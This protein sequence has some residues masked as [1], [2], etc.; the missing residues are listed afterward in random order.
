MIHKYMYTYIKRLIIILKIRTLSKS[1]G[2]ENSLCRR[3]FHSF[4]S[5]FVSNCFISR[6]PLLCQSLSPVWLCNSMNCSPA[7][8]SVH[9]IS[10]ARM[11]E[12]VPISFSGGSS[13]PRDWTCI[14]CEAGRFFTTEPPGY[15]LYRVNLSEQRLHI[16]RQSCRT[17]NRK[18]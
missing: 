18:Y 9:G 11:L 10:Q 14:S 3:Q 15:L 16:A 4:L 17:C 13:Q 1:T 7:G 5:K 6:N 2:N 12:G 8:S